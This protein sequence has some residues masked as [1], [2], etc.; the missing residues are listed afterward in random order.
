MAWENQRG[1][2]AHRARLVLSWAVVGCRGAG[3]HLV[4]VGSG[5]ERETGAQE[6]RSRAGTCA[7]V[8]GR[9]QGVSQ[10]SGER[11]KRNTKGGSSS[12]GRGEGISFCIGTAFSVDSVHYVLRGFSGVGVYHSKDTFTCLLTGFS[13]LRFLCVPLVSNTCVCVG[14]GV[15][16]TTVLT[17]LFSFFRA[18]TIGSCSRTCV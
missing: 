7:D 4:D 17:R 1:Q 6:H 15:V 13:P 16:S 3:G 18:L 5:G 8:C 14:G 12:R 2:G 9:V 10:G 11:V